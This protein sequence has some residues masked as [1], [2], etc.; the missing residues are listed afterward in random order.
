MRKG[1]T[2]YIILFCFPRGLDYIVLWI[3]LEK[4]WIQSPSRAVPD[5]MHM[6][7]LM[8]FHDYDCDWDMA[9]GWMDGGDR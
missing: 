1:V 3:G 8:D 9:A 5:V 4:P 2:K 7:A 6:V